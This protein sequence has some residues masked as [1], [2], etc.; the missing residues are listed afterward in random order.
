M[1]IQVSTLEDECAEQGKDWEEVLEQLAEEQDRMQ[2]LGVAPRRAE[3]KYYTI[4]RATDEGGAQQESALAQSVRA[5]ALEVGR[6]RRVITDSRG[7]PIGSVPCGTEDLGLSEHDRPQHS[8]E[9]EILE[10][11]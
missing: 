10:A 6:P 3:G 5:L 9:T 11:P 2:D 8:L 7:E 1:D 4:T